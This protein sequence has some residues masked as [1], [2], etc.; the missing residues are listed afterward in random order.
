MKYKNYLLKL[1]T[2][3]NYITHQPLEIETQFVGVSSGGFSL[4]LAIGR[5]FIDK[6]SWC[7]CI[8]NTR[9]FLIQSTS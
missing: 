6:V 7:T 9:L 5:L 8:E 1:Q 2:Y 4:C 3:N